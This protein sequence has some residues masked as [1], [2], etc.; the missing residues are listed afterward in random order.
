[1]GRGKL[2]MFLCDRSP[3]KSGGA[4][5]GGCKRIFIYLRPD[6]RC[7][8]VGKKGSRDLRLMTGRL[9]GGLSQWAWG[10]LWE[11]RGLTSMRQS[12]MLIRLPFGVYSRSIFVFG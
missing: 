9:G 6:I 3:A 10:C 1:M 2:C 8:E 12:G 5:M 11:R 7:S 4:R